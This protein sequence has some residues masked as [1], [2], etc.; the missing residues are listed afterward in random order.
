MLDQYRLVETVSSLERSTIQ[1]ISVTLLG[2][3]SF[4]VSS[5]AG[6]FGYRCPRALRSA[7][8]RPELLFAS[9]NT[10]LNVAQGI[11]DVRNEASGCPDVST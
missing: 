10:L 11:G 4:T 9:D 3:G 6:N 5:L 7:R 1:N 8:W 2:D